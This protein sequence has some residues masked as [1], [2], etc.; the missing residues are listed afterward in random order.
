MKLRQRF[1]TLRR[2]N[3][4]LSLVVIG[5][6]L[7]IILAPFWPKVAYR[8]KT[9]PPLVAQAE[10]KQKGPEQ[11]PK[12]NTIVI[13]S[14]KLQQE[15]YEGNQWTLNKGIWHVPGTGDP[16]S[17][18]NMVMAGH[19]FTYGGPA[20]LYHMDKVNRG[21]KIIVYWEQK[22][23]EYEVKDILVVPP[24]QVEVQNQ[25]EDPLLTLYTCTPLV[26]AANRLV[27]QAEPLEVNR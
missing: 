21:D 2:F 11:I 6:C 20:V 5:L 15:I 24:T 10:G 1:F 22:K 16:V 13:P 17:G 19:R 25:T 26:T 8:F 7:Y 12:E 14:M 3:N 27:I 23:H 18:G 4:V 9:E